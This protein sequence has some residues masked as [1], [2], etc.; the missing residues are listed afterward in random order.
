MKAKG[1]GLPGRFLIMEYTSLNPHV[2]ESWLTGSPGLLG[3]ED[4]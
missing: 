3:M 1:F 4:L 2:R